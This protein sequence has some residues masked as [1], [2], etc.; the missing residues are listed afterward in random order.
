L[1]PRGGALPW[2]MKIWFYDNN[3]LTSGFVGT[4]S[5]NPH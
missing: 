1:W 3:K 4:K 2:I 5:F